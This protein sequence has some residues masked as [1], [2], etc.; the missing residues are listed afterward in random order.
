MIE[1]EI[2]LRCPFLSSSK[3]PGFFVPCPSVRAM[4][5]QRAVNFVLLLFHGLRM[6]RSQS[7]NVPR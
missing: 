6:H 2:N 3:L 5:V 7:S 4:A 1:G